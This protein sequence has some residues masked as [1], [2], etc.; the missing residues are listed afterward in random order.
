MRKSD[1]DKCL[2]WVLYMQGQTKLISGLVA[3][4]MCIREV[5]V[6]LKHIIHM[7]GF[8]FL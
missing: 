2:T 4:C 7:D 8:V 6:P 1:D 3:V 5:E